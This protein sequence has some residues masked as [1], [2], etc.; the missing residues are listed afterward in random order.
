MVAVELNERD[1]SEKTSPRDIVIEE[2]T[3]GT[4]T[5]NTGQNSIGL[6]SDS[7]LTLRMCHQLM[8]H[9]ENKYFVIVKEIHLKLNSRLYYSSKCV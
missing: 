5:T 3:D 9:Y 4:P 7:Q 2:F 6:A 8:F 1:K